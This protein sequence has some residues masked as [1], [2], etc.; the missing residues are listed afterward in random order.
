[1]LYI[2]YTVA[3][4]CVKRSAKKIAASPRLPVMAAVETRLIYV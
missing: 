1:M 2:A 3:I 4:E